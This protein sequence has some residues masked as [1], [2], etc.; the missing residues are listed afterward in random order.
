MLD[1]FSLRVRRP[2]IAKRSSLCLLCFMWSTGF[3]RSPGFK[4]L[5][6]R[7]MP[8]GLEFTTCYAMVRTTMRSCGYYGW[9]WTCEGFRDKGL[10]LCYKCVQR[11]LL[12]VSLFF[13]RLRNPR[14]N[15]ATHKQQVMRR[16]GA[17]TSQLM[18]HTSHDRIVLRDVHLTTPASY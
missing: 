3:K 2:E 17:Y 4:F 18:H 6:N 9:A 15:L 7:M 8:L 16:P 1:I 14:L 10:Y 11:S 5:R 12:R 13:T